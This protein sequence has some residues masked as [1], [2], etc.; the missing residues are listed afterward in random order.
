MATTVL[1]ALGDLYESVSTPNQL[2]SLYSGVIP[3]GTQKLFPCA[4]FVHKGTVPTYQ[5]GR[6]KNGDSG[7]KYETTRGTFQLW[8]AGTNDVDPQQNG[9]DAA[10]VAAE[11]LMAVLTP[12]ALTVD[13]AA[14]TVLRIDKKTI[15]YDQARAGQGQFI[16]RADVDVTAQVDY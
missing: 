13:N 15:S 4:R 6:G 11:S 12:L 10:D 3:E 8:Y 16:F 2:P 5:K 7:I 14:A 9:F 1:Q